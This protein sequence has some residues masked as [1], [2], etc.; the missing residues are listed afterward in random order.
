MIHRILE[1]VNDMY[2]HATD[3]PVRDYYKYDRIC[4][5][6]L[7]SRP[8]CAYCGEPI[9]TDY[10]IRVD[11]KYYCNCS[12]CEDEAYMLIRPEYLEMIS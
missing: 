9:Q 5:E 8:K 4:S 7:N 12:E 10:A 2:F 11:G 6:W 1:D 3:D